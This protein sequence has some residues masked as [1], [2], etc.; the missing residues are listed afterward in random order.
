MSYDLLRFAHVMGVLMMGAGLCGVFVCDLRGRAAPTC[1]A[2]REMAALVALF[3]DALVVPGALVLGTAGAAMVA[4]V[5]GWSAFQ[6]PWLAS[7]IVLFALEFVEG[8]TITRLAFLRLRR[9]SRAGPSPELARARA[10]RLATFTHFLD[11]PALTVI[12]WLGMTRPMDWAPV[13]IAV[14]LAAGV[15]VALT[16][17]VPRLLP[18]RSDP[19]AAEAA[20]RNGAREAGVDATEGAS[21]AHDAQSPPL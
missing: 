6:M 18:W 17:A 2:A 7:M 4:V 11:L 16:V 12:V 14:A 20:G 8:N 21:T 5:Y 19:M 10:S 1:A 9:L 15:A 13:G 3:Y